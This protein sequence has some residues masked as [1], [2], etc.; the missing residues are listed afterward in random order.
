MNACKLLVAIAVV[1]AAPLAGTARAG[2]SAQLRVGITIVRGCEARTP[3]EL[4]TRDPV[5]VACSAGTPYHVAVAEQARPSASRSELLPAAGGNAT[6]VATL[7][8]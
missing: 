3:V 7:T 6:M 1:L 8:F 5:R 2:E 4:E